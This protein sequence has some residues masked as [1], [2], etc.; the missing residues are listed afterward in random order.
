MPYKDFDAFLQEQSGDPIAF[1]FAGK[2]YSVP[3]EMPATL[4]LY[5][6]RLRTESDTEAESD[7]PEPWIIGICRRVIGSEHVDAMIADGITV[8]GLKE[9]NDWVMDCYR[10]E[11]SDPPTAETPAA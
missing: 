7:I 4:A 9:I 10:G 2:P 11:P 5:L 1:R 8:A 6:A 3:A